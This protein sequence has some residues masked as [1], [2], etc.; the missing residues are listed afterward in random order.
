MECPIDAGTSFREDY[1]AQDTPP[2]T[3]KS[4]AD[5]ANLS[6]KQS[7]TNVLTLPSQAVPPVQ[8]EHPPD[9]G[10][11]SREEYGAQDTPPST[12]MRN[13]DQ[14]HSFRRGAEG[15]ASDGQPGDEDN[16]EGNGG[17]DTDVEEIT[18]GDNPGGLGGEGGGL[19]MAVAPGDGSR[20]SLA[21][22]GSE[23]GAERRPG[24]ENRASRL[25]DELLEGNLGKRLLEFVNG[26][27]D[28]KKPRSS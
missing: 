15:N 14:A 16:R 19:G 12:S 20:G 2:S 1:G 5:Q 9:A 21:G 24:E 26:G 10:T 6:R 7:L 28:A 13:T 27:S 3:S 17:T 23:T 8:V 4:R 25:E 22:R 18:G 11:S